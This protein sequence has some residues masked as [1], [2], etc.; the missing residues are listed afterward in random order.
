MTAASRGARTLVV[1][2]DPAPSLADAFMRPVGPEPRGIPTRRGALHA[3]EIDAPAA[4]GRWL[5]DRRKALERIALRGTWLDKEDV[6][7]L[8]QLSLPGIDELAA[9]LEVS[10]L[11][12]AGAYQVVIVDTAP[13]G[14]TLRMLDTPEA[15]RALASVFDSMQ[16]KHRVVVQALRGRWSPD[17]EDVVISGMEDEARQLATLLRDRERAQ[18]S[19]ITLPEMLAVE[20]TADA[21]S[22]LAQR[23]LEVSEVIVNRITTPPGRACAWCDARHGVDA[24][25][26]QA[27]CQRLPATSITSLSARDSEPRGVRALATIGA[28]IEA[29]ARLP[30][31]VKARGRGA[32]LFRIQLRTGAVP[33]IAAPGTRLLLFGGKGGVGK[34]TCAAAAAV[35]IA[36]QSRDRRVLLVST[37]PAH[38][39][40]DVLAAPVS[41]AAGGLHNGP[42]NLVVREID[43]AQA[44]RT[45]RRHYAAAIDVWFD[46][47]V[48][49]GS[50]SVGVDASLDRR[51]MHGLMDLAPPGIDE[52][53]AVIEVVEAL[54]QRHPGGADII[55][56]DT[57]P[58]GHA[59]RLLEMP[60]LVQDWARALMSILLKYQ[61]V[62]GVGELGA[63][64]LR[65]SQGLG[66]LRTLLM[67]PAKTSFIAV[68][69]PAAL[70]REETHRLLRRLAAMQVDVPLVIVN[71]V[72]R[73]TCARCQAGARE[74]RQQVR[75]MQRFRSDTRQEPIPVVVAPTELPPPRGVPA[76]RRWQSS[77]RIA[78][79]GK[80]ILS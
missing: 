42:P 27:L 45:A 73:G 67:D 47:L 28:E 20:E 25:S 2:T 33:R 36:L 71:V 39:L 76:L 22:A 41:D 24:L 58:S 56:M 5:Q 54:E 62:T 40:G 80:L 8:L 74:E 48:R 31:A 35:A 57:A 38:S 49:G 15:L 52:L 55:V 60:Q 37:D 11:A 23:G 32:R 72:G 65:I 12:A 46:R 26:V 43:A 63:V 44:F 17:A 30:G 64:L 77:W 21:V 10:R 68:T 4:L 6:S 50:G 69:R 19:W 13:T 14:H 9:L 3:V 66:R 53:T 51:V 18:Y 75:R 29:A 16:D 61:P 70:P 59:L 78:A 79:P 7:R 34:T 1:S